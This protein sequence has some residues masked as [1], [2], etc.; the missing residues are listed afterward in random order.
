MSSNTRTTKR[1]RGLITRPTR[2]DEKPARIQPL[3]HLAVKPRFVVASLVAAATCASTTPDAVKRPRTD[4]GVPTQRE[5]SGRVTPTSCS[6][7]A[8]S[9]SGDTQESAC[10]PL[11]VPP[12]SVPQHI[13]HRGMNFPGAI[14]TLKPLEKF[15][16]SNR[17][18]L[19]FF[20][21]ALRPL[22]TDFLKK[23]CDALLAH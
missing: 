11:H 18:A 2:S 15:L 3:P 7:L 19:R 8:V 22:T 9:E 14:V 10:C 16:L 4:K 13:R 20:P 12:W 6:L 17:L 21:A 23:G 5:S 1:K